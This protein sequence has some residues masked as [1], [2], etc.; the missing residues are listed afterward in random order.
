MCLLVILGTCLAPVSV[1][2][3]KKLRPGVFSRETGAAQSLFVA[4]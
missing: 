2:Q 3:K 4:S 1:Q